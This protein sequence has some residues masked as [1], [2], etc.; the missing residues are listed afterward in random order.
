MKYTTIQLGWR[1]LSYFLRASNGKGHGIHSPYVFDFVI[2]IL[3]DDRT[4]YA[5]SSISSVYHALLNDVTEIKEKEIFTHQAFNTQKQTVQSIARSKENTIKYGQLLF[6]MVDYYAPEKI[7]VLGTSLGISAAYL[8]SA[9]SKAHVFAVESSIP[10]AEISRNNFKKLSLD[11][12]SLENGQ[13]DLTLTSIL[14]KTP[15][16]DFMWVN[17]IQEYELQLQ[18][19]NQL[20]KVKQLSWSSIKFIKVLLLKKLGK[21]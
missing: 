9:N 4:F 10:L 13:L 2:R 14:S 18:I 16:F 7:L 17:D 11:N 1:Y 21:K 6:R 8:A 12:I 15:S 20:L 19:F 5:F 3:N